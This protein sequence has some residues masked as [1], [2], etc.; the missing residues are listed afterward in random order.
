MLTRLNK[1]SIDTNHTPACLIS[2]LTNLTSLHSNKKVSEASLS[3]LT[4]LV[5]LRVPIGNISLNCNWPKI[6]EISLHAAAYYDLDSNKIAKYPNLTTLDIPINVGAEWV[7]SL[8]QLRNLSSL[9]MRSQNYQSVRQLSQ[10]HLTHL[11]IADV[12]QGAMEYLYLYTNLRSLSL[13]SYRLHKDEYPLYLTTL[14]NLCS[15]RYAI[16][17]GKGDLNVLT[18]LTN[19]TKLEAWNCKVDS[20]TTLEHLIC[21]SPNNPQS[22]SKLVNLRHLSLR[23]IDI[24]DHDILGAKHLTRL[25]VHDA[26]NLTNAIFQLTNLVNLCLFNQN[27]NFSVTGA[28]KLPFLKHIQIGFENNE[29]IKH[30]EEYDAL[31]FINKR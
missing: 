8:L 6:Q 21:N 13:R 19:L 24:K 30:K 23:D 10:L 3:Q 22:F 11:G 17:V 15:L 31:P 2:T 1:L 14:T 29:Y 26:S 4:N 16:H 20:L 27:D 9:S 18:G 12:A 7:T 25:F 5:S 28:R